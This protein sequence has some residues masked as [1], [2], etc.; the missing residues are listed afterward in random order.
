MR[1]YIRHPSSIPIEY[2]IAHTINKQQEA[3]QNISIGGLSFQSSDYIKKNS[4]V[5]LH[6]PNM[7]PPFFAQG[8]VVWCT[9]R[10]KSYNIG[11]KFLD[12]QTAF[13]ARMVEQIC[14]IEGYR[15]KVSEIE[16][17]QLSSEEAA[18]EWIAKYAKSFP[19]TAV[20]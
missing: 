2:K 4:P 14:Y 13:R 9:K 6:I 11:V 16:G 20:H 7:T 15:K 18:A 19:K 12:I 8:V 17:R 10:N 3:L 1:K 5:K